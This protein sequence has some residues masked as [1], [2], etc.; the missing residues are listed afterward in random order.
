[1]CFYLKLDIVLLSFGFQTCEKNNRLHFL[2]LTE[3]DYLLMKVSNKIE[4][5]DLIHVKYHATDNLCDSE[6]YWEKA[7]ILSFSPYS[8]TSIIKDFIDKYKTS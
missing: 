7:I 5:A 4:N 6:P 3:S 1:M 8:D 2:K